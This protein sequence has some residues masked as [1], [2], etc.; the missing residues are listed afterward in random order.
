MKNLITFFLLLISLSTFSQNSTTTQ[1]QQ[2][3]VKPSFWSNVRFGGG[4]GFGFGNRSTTINVSPSA[5]YDFQNGFAMGLGVGYLYSK[6]DAFKSNVISPNLITLYNPAE[7]IQLSAE[8]EH[9][10]VNQ[11]LGNASYKNDFP[12]LYLGVAY[13]TGWA[14]FGVRYDVLFD[15]RDSVFTSPFSPIIR[16]YF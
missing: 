12:A 15:E 10:F 1:T 5:I 8:F 7:Q 9:L 13:R 6:V 11:N 14:A 3:N 4:L 16:I 2:P